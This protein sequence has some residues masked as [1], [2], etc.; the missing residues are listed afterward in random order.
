MNLPSYIQLLRPDV[1]WEH[2]DYDCLKQVIT[3]A[4]YAHLRYRWVLVL[5]EGFTQGGHSPTSLHYKGKAVDGH[6]ENKRGRVVPLFDQ[7]VLLCRF[8]WGGIGLYPHWAH[9]GFHADI[10]TPGAYGQRAFWW[11]D[12]RDT[13]VP[14]SERYRPLEMRYWR[15]IFV[16]G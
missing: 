10:R 7:F 9:P 8:G 11:R 4:R 2:L 1:D 6:F 14:V 16:G 13:S 3:T 12:D 5:H 15:I